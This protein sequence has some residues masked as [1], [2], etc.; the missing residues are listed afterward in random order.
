MAKL[1][2]LQDES[3]LREEG[4]DDFIDI[5][6]VYERFL[7]RDFYR[8]LIDEIATSTSKELGRAPFHR[9]HLLRE[10]DEYRGPKIDGYIQRLQRHF[11]TTDF[12]PVSRIPS[13]E[14]AAKCLTALL[15]PALM[16][17]PALTLM[18]SEQFGMVYL[19]LIPLIGL[20]TYKVIEKEFYFVLYRLLSPQT[21]RARRL[22]TSR[23]AAAKHKLS[24]YL[25]KYE[26]DPETVLDFVSEYLPERITEYIQQAETEI[27][28]LQKGQVTMRKRLRGVVSAPEIPEEVKQEIAA[29]TTVVHEQ[30]DARIT[31]WNAHIQQLQRFRGE[32][33]DKAERL[34]KT[35]DAKVLLDKTRAQLAE[36]RRELGISDKRMVM[37][38]EGLNTLLEDIRSLIS[39][40]RFSARIEMGED[41][42]RLTLPEEGE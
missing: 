33:L 31:H 27:A 42:E 15:L 22:V 13:L 30:I 21:R 41:L 39:T 29:E 34:R 14:V 8:D 10:L 16:L 17:F 20:L 32:V 9:D 3:W 38:R 25:A 4:D 36:T 24:A 5:A 2:A 18:S 11:E 12:T 6:K 7:A 40:T 26:K 28:R 19:F 1:P 37:Q 23:L 35:V